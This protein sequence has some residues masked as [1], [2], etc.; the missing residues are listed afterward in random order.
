M[1]AAELV[2][3]AERQMVVCNACRYCEGFCAVFPAM[4]RRR[5]FTPG[6]LTY[7]ANLCFDCRGCYYAC[8]YAP[9]HEFAIN[10]PQVFSALRADTYRDYTWPGILS[11]LYR[12]T[13]WT[14][15]I[16]SV[17]G[18][19]AVLLLVLGLQ[20]PGVLV[21]RHVG[22]GAFYRVVPYLAMVVPALAISLYGG[23]ALAIGTVRFWRDTHGRLRDLLDPRAFWRATGDAFSLRYLGGAGGGCNYPAERFS[24]QRRW[25]HHLV[26]YGFLLDLAATTVAAG[27]EHLLDWQAPY[28]YL[29]WPVV[30]GTVGG[31]MLVAGT[32][33]LL[34][35]KWRSDRAPAEGQALRMDVAFLVILLLTS[36]TG[37]ALLALRETAAMGAL[38][39]IH[40]G[41]VA[42][43]F[44]TLPYGKFAH[45]FYRYA[46][47]VRNAVE[48]RRG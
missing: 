7:L 19:V 23:A 21:S 1:P 40:L 18:V 5:R 37:L 33:G 25:L 8:Q 15:A 20:G 38:L 45:V 34:W 44:L 16:A 43:L 32:L 9:P 11:G 30:L 41:M 2:Q 10:V 29:S 36:L 48:E 46:A 17:A 27:Y 12:R 47:L 28:P 4:E 42:A 39:A 6:D 22:E 35:L 24:Q 14:G 26:F 31:V 3:E 13:G